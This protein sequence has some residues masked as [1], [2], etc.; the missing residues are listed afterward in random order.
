M[1]EP[2]DIDAGEITDKGY[3]NQRISLKRRA[4]NSEVVT[5]SAAGSPNRRSQRNV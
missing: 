3:I 2:P 5:L 1:T 4:C